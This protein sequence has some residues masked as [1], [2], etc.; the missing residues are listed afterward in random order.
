MKSEVIKKKL[1][2]MCMLNEK[3]KG[4][5][6]YSERLEKETL[7]YKCKN[8]KRR[9]DFRENNNT[10]ETIREEEWSKNNYK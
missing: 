4:C 1:C 10:F 7:T 9:E 2:N 5:L 3:E 8:Y 6:K